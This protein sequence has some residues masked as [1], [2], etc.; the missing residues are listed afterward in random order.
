MGAKLKKDFEKLLKREGVFLFRL[1]VFVFCEGVFAMFVLLV[2][3]LMG[4]PPSPRH[5]G[6]F[7]EGMKNAFTSFT[8]M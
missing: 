8:S 3:M 2:A 1:R 4:H 7:K 5:K 6:D